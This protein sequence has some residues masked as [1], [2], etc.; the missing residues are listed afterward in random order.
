VHVS[1]TILYNLRTSI[2]FSSV[3]KITYLF[4]NVAY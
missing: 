1:K 4:A 2:E 3:Q